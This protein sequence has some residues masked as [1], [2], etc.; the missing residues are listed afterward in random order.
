MYQKAPF[1]FSIIITIPVLNHT[2]VA[3]KAS[4]TNIGLDEY[5]IKLANNQKIGKTITKPVRTTITAFTT[6][7]IEITN[8]YEIRPVNIKDKKSP[9]YTS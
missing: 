7:I 5:P 3:M 8:C 9:K 6:S 2:A 4:F 1:L